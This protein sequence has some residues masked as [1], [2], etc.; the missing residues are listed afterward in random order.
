MD[1]G[2]TP[3]IADLEADYGPAEAA[4][5]VA[6]IRAATLRD[7]ANHMPGQAADDLHRLADHQEAQ[8]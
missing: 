4:R 6:S 2:Y 5:L 1:S 7:A 8:S 3:T